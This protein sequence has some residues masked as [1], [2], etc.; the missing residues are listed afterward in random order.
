MVGLITT[1][2][3]DK[4]GLGVHIRVRC[5]PIKKKK[6]IMVRRVSKSLNLLGP[7][8]DFEESLECSE[9]QMALNKSA[10]RI[11][12]TYS[13]EIKITSHSLGA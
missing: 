3:S 5:V 12:R 1:A 9:P 4:L 7:E 13:C 2:M 10:I 8:S 11:C 6:K